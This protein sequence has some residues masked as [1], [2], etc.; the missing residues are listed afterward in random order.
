LDPDFVIE[1]LSSKDTELITLSIE[2]DGKTAAAIV[3]FALH[4][5]ILAGDNWLYSADFPGYLAEAMA[6]IF[7]DDFMTVFCNGC[8]GN[9]N[10]IDYTDKLHGRGYMMTQRIGYMLAVAAQVAMSGQQSVE[11]NEV[12][13][14]REMVSLSRYKI[15]QEKL[16]WADEVLEKAKTAPSK[17]TVDG[18]PDEFYAKLWL[19]MHEKENDDDTAEVMVIRIGNVG[20][21][22][23][24][25]EMFYEIGIDI[26]KGS[27]AKH[28]IVLELTND[29]IGYIPN[30]QAYGQGGYEDTPGSTVYESGTG[31]RLADSAVKQLNKLFA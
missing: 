21:V 23:L 25:G 26:K 30:R 19:E 8:C 27:P 9:I 18:L 31:E 20:I 29:A 28:T 4:P 7:G 10:H 16:K 1:P 12:G 2:Q 3:N 24:P 15:D 11:G 5:A 17:G 6:K 13:V 22:S 14:S